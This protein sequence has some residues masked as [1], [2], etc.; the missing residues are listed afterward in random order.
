MDEVEGEEAMEMVAEH[1]KKR[2]QESGKK[3]RRCD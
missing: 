1:K 3:N 2:K